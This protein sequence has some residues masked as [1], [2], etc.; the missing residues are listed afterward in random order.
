MRA[1]LQSFSGRFLPNGVLDVFVQVALM[2]ATY[3]AYRLVRG[4][5]DDPQG[6]AVAFQNGRS[7]IGIEQSLGIFVE[8]RIQELF[9]PTS[10]VG[11]AASWMYLNAQVTVT[12]GAL[13]YLYL[14]HNSSF[15]FVRNMFIVAWAI[16]LLGYMVF[17]TAPPRFFPEWG[18][19]DSVADF[20]GIDPLTTS[21]A[22]ALFN[23]YAAVPSMHVAFALMIGVPLA[24]LAKHRAVRWFWTAYP[25]ARD[26][27][28]RHD[29]QPLRLR[30]D[31]RRADRRRAPPP[32][33]SGSRVPAPSGASAP[34]RR[35]S[36]P[37]ERDTRRPASAARRCA[38]R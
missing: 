38:T 19:V 2:E 1:R 33:P 3:M 11:D 32:P 34:R 9:G 22:N 30:R 37:D 5:I 26:V 31:P 8:P 28:D 27:R 23:P 24:L 15:Y 36:P 18:F 14:R 7:V 12:L 4:W 17:P 20:T 29:R 35:A 10:F 13:V 25:A 21:G 6:A 16:A